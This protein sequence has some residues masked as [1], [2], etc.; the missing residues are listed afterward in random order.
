MKFKRGDKVL[1][2][3]GLKDTDR[4]SNNWTGDM[5]ASIATIGIVRAVYSPHNITVY[6]KEAGTWN[7]PPFVLRCVNT[8]PNGQMLF[9]F[10]CGD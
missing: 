7:Y 9:N 10:M 6:T 8:D 4:W 2:T 5:D 1:I 3:R